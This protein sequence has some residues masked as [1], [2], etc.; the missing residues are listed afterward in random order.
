MNIK[1]YNIYNLKYK[2]NKNKGLLG[3]IFFF[4]LVGLSAQAQESVLLKGKVEASNPDIEKIH[5]INLNLEKGAVTNTEGEFEIFANENDSLYVSSVQF[6]NTT[7]I[8]TRKM[9]ENKSLNIQLQDKMNELAEVVIDDIKLSGHL[10]NDLSRISITEVEKKYELQNNLNDFIRKDR[11]MNPYEKAMSNGGIR[12]D[13]IAGAVIDKLS[14]DKQKPRTYTPRDLANKSIAIVGNEFFREDLDL[15]ANEV[16]NFVYFCTEDS[17][18][19]QLVLNDNAF[20]LIEYFQT[21]IEDFRQ[22]RG[23]ALNQSSQLPG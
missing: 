7:V 18:F 12:L 16:C 23:S 6:Y 19:R 22:R 8:V 11:E 4:C 9:I 5:I 3:L 17:V 10:A 15:N 1:N 2:F 20:V 14:G 13:K 21:R